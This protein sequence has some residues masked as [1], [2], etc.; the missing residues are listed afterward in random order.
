M[1]SRLS[2]AADLKKCSGDVLDDV[3]SLGMYATDAGIGPAEFVFLQDN[4]VNPIVAIRKN[5]CF[6][7]MVYS[8]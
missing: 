6:I 8:Y 7:Q 1:N 2:F 3:Y 5:I 4:S